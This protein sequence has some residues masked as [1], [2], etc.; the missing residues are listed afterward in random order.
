MSNENVQALL[1]KLREELQITEVDQTSRDLMQH[2]EKDIEIFLADDDDSPD[3]LNI[4]GT[5]Q[6][7]NAEFA[8]THPAAERLMRELIDVLAKMG[9]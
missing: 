2:L 5:T 7:L 3:T 8:S 1:A 6:A 9:I 4:L